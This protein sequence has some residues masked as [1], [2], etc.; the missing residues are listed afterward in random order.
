MEVEKIYVT[1]PFP[2]QLE[3]QARMESARQRISRSALV[4]LAVAEY[5]KRLETHP[6]K[7]STRERQPA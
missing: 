1:V 3:Y 7:E 4:R 2:P 6:T 5:L